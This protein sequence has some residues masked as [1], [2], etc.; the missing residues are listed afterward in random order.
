[1][2]DDGSTDKTEEMLWSEFPEAGLLS[3]PENSGFASAANQGL[4]RVKTPYAA[5]LNND[6]EVD[7]D[8][9]ENVI[10][11]VTEYPEYGF[12]LPG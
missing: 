6:T 2:V 5:L 11:G 4:L 9:A 10:K 12:L 1:M 7:R 3:I 8:W